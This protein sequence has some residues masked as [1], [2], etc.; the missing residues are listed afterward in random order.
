MFSLRLYPI[1]LIFLLVGCLS[2]QTLQHHQLSELDKGISAEE[3]NKRIKILPVATHIVSIN[4]RNFEF[5]KYF[6]NNGIQTDIYLL[7][8]ENNL[9][10]YW[11]YVTEFRRQ[12]DVDLNSA[13]SQVLDSI[14]NF[15]R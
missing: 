13:L 5:K 2:Q 3:V 7:A 14:K 15:A 11:G 8:Y 4:H 12:Q 10:I 9:L 1:V 6:L